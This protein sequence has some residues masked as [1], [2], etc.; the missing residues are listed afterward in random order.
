[1][2][3]VRDSV[4]APSEAALRFARPDAAGAG[5]VGA[6]RLAYSDELRALWRRDP[7]AFRTLAELASGDQDVKLVDDCGDE[8]YA[9]RRIL[10]AVL[11]QLARSRRD[12]ALR[13]ERGGRRGQ[14]AS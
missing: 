9:P 5:R 1:V 7:D 4:F 3:R 8:D 6:W 14:A 12:E 10:G 13:R 2:I 11:K